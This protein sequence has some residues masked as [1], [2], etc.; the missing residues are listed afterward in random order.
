MRAQSIK[1]PV[2]LEMKNTESAIS[3]LKSSLS[4]L[5]KDSGL[6]KSIG[7]EIDSVEKKFKELSASA[8]RP[9]SNTSSIKNFET[10]FLRL[11]DRIID[12]EQAFQSLG[13]KDLD[14]RAI[15]GA[16]EQFKKLNLAVVNTKKELAGINTKQMKSA[17]LDSTTGLEQVFKNL[18]NFGGGSLINLDSFEKTFSALETKS[19]KLSEQLLTAQNNLE[20]LKQSNSQADVK[21][22]FFDQAQKQIQ[23]F[24]SGT[25]LSKDAF[26]NLLK[27]LAGQA[28]MTP[29]RFLDFLGLNKQNLFTGTAEKIQK[30]LN[31]AIS[32]QKTA[33]ANNQFKNIGKIENIESQISGLNNYINAVNEAK[34]RLDELQ[35]SEASQAQLADATKNY[36]TAVANLNKFQASCIE[37]NGALGNLSP[38][39]AQIR[40]A[41]GTLP[42]ATSA[43]SAELERLNDTSNKLSQMKSRLAYFFSFYKVMGTIK[44]AV[45]EAVTTIKDLDSVMT[46]IA[47]VTQKTQED[48]WKQMETYSAIANE[49]AVSIKGVYEISQ[50]YYQQGLQTSQ[51]MDLT[52][53][54]LKMA[55]IANLDYATATDYMTV[56]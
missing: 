28:G 50:L 18:N 3:A 53:E 42:A 11:G 56:A 40:G 6:Y 25:N 51:V 35:N 48:L 13:F 47:V 37:T 21:L 27:P 54:T 31:D 8:S 22:G 38:A 19:A 24:T 29:D 52:V 14:L 23:K 12:I 34:S 55:K 20:A 10:Q 39:I 26:A 49:Y 36:E 16:E 15:P 30:N 4:G 9:F 2:E 44:S 17:L 33:L 5:S 43:A 32:S 1:I 45:N 46:Q 41:M 7:K